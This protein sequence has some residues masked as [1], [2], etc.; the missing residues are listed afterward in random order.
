MNHRV[1]QAVKNVQD[2]PHI[3]PVDPYPII[4]LYADK[5]GLEYFY[6]I[7]HIEQLMRLI[8]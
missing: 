6:T 5:D 4:T 8:K 1:L 7:W 2:I 3:K